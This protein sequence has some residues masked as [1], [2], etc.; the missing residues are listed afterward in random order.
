MGIQ[1][2]KREKRPQPYQ[3]SVISL[4]LYIPIHTILMFHMP[5]HL[6]L[7]CW[8]SVVNPYPA[9]VPSTSSLAPDETPSYLTI[10]NLFV[11][12]QVVWYIKD[13]YKTQVSTKAYGTLKLYVWIDREKANNTWL[14]G[15]CQ[16][17]FLSL[18]SARKNVNSH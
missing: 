15:L 2:Y 3:P 13:L 4:V 18:I 6:I 12:F 17:S 11:R 8:L 5:L 16:W 1:R 14:R 9:I 7:L 10:R